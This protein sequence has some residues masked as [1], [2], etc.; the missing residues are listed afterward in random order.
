MTFHEELLGLA[1]ELI[2]RNEPSQAHLRRA[3]S[4]AYYAFFHLLISE[5]T[6]NWKRD[7]SRDALGRMFDHGLMR[8]VSQRVVDW[9]R[10]PFAGEDPEL[11]Q[12]LR[13]VAESFVQLQDRR[14]LADYDNGKRWSYVESL[15]AVTRAREAF[16][17]WATI[18]SED[19]AQEYLVSLLIRPRE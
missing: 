7:S 14:H 17:V 4:T 6:L 5:A 15:Q 10:S 11:V 13:T 9:R 19:L 12:R 16:S 2:H 8:K 1:G 3:V 18:R